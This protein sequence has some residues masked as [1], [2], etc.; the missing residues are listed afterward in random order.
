MNVQ[1]ALKTQ[2]IQVHTAFKMILQR[3]LKAQKKLL[4]RAY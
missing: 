4:K 3:F 2:T 1:E